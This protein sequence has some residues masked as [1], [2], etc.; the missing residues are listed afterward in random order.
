MK[1]YIRFLFVCG[2]IM[3]LSEIWKQWCLT[4]LL[5]NGAY[6]WWYFPFQLCS[7]PMYICLLIPWVSDR[8]QRILLTFLMTFSLLGGIFTFFDTSGLHY[9]YPPLTVHSFFWHILLIMIGVSAGIMK[10][11]YTR[12]TA[13]EFLCS[14][15]CYLSCCLIATVLNIIFRPYG[16]IDMFYISPYYVMNQKV[17]AQIAEKLGN[18]AGILIYILAILFGASLL[19]LFWHYFENRIYEN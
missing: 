4:F 6:N 18:T 2:I 9:P 10:S 1:K 16:D 7:I 19:H 14:A 12:N 11:K 3:L 8:M 13:G 5:N 17:F 15:F